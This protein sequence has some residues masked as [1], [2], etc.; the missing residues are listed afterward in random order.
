[1][2]IPLP[3]LNESELDDLCGPTSSESGCSDD[4]PSDND[5]G[6]FEAA[7]TS[8]ELWRM[9]KN[10]PMSDVGSDS[11]DDGVNPHNDWPIHSRRRT[12][13]KTGPS[14]IPEL[15]LCNNNFAPISCVC[16]LPFAYF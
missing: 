5:N 3:G 11:G 12:Q 1:M 15:A 9:G 4:W 14:S 8:Y 16:F 2:S 10:Q 6:R 7:L 13:R